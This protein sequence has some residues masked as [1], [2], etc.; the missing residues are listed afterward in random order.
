[1]HG[2]LVQFLIVYLEFS[3]N[4][5]IILTDC[6]HFWTC[7]SSNSIIIMVCC[8]DYLVKSIKLVVFCVWSYEGKKYQANNYIKGTKKIL[9]K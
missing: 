2:L 4:F 7:L 3:L 1:M 9:R 5:D 6:H 8:S